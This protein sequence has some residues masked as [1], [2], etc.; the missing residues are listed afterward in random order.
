M[1]WVLISTDWQQNY[2]ELLQDT[3][4]K[5]EGAYYPIYQISLTQEENMKNQVVVDANEL[6]QSITQEKKTLRVG[7]SGYLLSVAYD[8]DKAFSTLGM[9][10]KI[11]GI[12][13]LF[14]TLLLLATMWYSLRAQIIN[15]I[16]SLIG[17]IDKLKKEGLQ[18]RIPS[19]T[20]KEVDSIAQS[21]NQLAEKLEQTTTSINELD[22]EILEKGTIVQSQLEMR[23]Q[24]EAIL[25][26]APYGIITIDTKG[27]LLSF[28]QA[29]QTMFGYTEDE[30]LGK[31]IE[32][33][34][35]KR[36]SQHHQAYINH[37]METKESRIIGVRDQKGRLGREFEALRKS[38]EIFPIQLSIA[39]VSS[40]K[41]LIFT[42]IIKDITDQKAANQALV[43]AKEVAEAAAKA[44][45][46]FLAIMSHEIRTPMNGIIGMLELLMDNHLTHSQHHQAYLAQSS[47][48]SLLNLLNDI[49]DFSKI[50]ADKL[51]LDEHHFNLRD[52]LGTFSESMVSSLTNPNVELVLDTIGIHES[53]ILADS[54]RIRQI[55]ANLVGNAIKFTERGEI[56]IKAEIENH[57]SSQ[58]KLVGS[59][60]DSGIGIPKERAEHLFDKF[61]QVDAS[62]TRKFGGTGLGLAIVKKLCQIMHGDIEVTSELGKGSCFK[63]TLLVGKSE[64]STR[65]LPSTDI[66]KLQVL[67][68]DD[69]AI[70]R[71]VLSKQLEHWGA[72][73]TEAENAE[74]A[75]AE[76]ERHS[77]SDGMSFDIAFLDMQMPDINGIELSQRLHQGSSTRDIKLI[78]MTSLDA[79]DEQNTFKK[80][81]FSGYFVKPATTSDLLS[82]LKVIASED[83]HDNELVTHNY[84]SGL[85]EQTTNQEEFPQGLNI[86]VVEDNRV[87]Q[88]V[89]SGLL[90]QFDCQCDVAENGKLAIEKLKQKSDYHLV[91]MDCQMPEM[92]GYEATRFI[93]HGE[94]GDKAKDLPILAMTAN[95]MDSDREACKVAGM[96]DFL[97]KPV[98]KALLRKKLI[99]WASDYT[100]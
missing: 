75:L 16:T 95:A 99:Q 78:M 98:N 91:L 49:L 21:V 42:G 51:E 8:N 25:D 43:E 50:E 79:I 59:V 44:K 85:S 86:L 65:V 80:L 47:A 83:F 56:V 20:V 96:N 82:A 40:S 33:L 32:L 58:W 11:V 14:A 31:S 76:C 97:T 29:A 22:K 26:T 77:Q 39:E 62:T 52:M 67:V 100:R 35:G 48:L 90:K 81:G 2:Q 34:M 45:S 15:P 92:D 60:R 6:P 10:Y 27:K 87:N 7:Q 93:R 70:N 17:Y 3:F 53:M 71:E 57:S 46:E 88:V 84:L 1:G 24:L 19:Q 13:L 55:F 23:Q 61:S 94:A 28:N 54:T 36:Y 63:F 64:Q 30:V 4:S 68:V 73:V 89:I 9:M 37:Y 12:G 18:Y 74:Q 5:L 66:S 72:E 69:N 41:G 38:G